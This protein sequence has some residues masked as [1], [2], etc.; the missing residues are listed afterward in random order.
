TADITQEFLLTLGISCEVLGFTTSQWRGGQSRSQWKWRLRPSR[1]GRLN[2]ILHII[3]KTA[4]DRRTSTASNELR[5]MLRPDLP[6]ENIDGEALQWAAK[7]LMMLPQRRK[8]LVVLSDGAPVDDS[9]LKANGL[10]Y[11][12]DHLKI[13]VNDIVEAGDIHLSA[14]G[15][16][17]H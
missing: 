5:Y 8:Y 1:P 2:D 7:R 17:Y 6:K 4:A 16:G 14:V 11:L 15:I 12:S 3:Y 9:T 10:T 13:V